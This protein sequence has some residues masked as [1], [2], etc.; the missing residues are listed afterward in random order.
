M[1]DCAVC[2]ATWNVVLCPAPVVDGKD[3]ARAFLLLMHHSISHCEKK[4]CTC[5]DIWRCADKAV[6]I[7]F[8]VYSLTV[9]PPPGNKTAH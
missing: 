4:K 5:V 9:W 2:A 1:A 3:L 6:V 8:F 7:P